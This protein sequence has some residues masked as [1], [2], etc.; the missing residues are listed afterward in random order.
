MSDTPHTLHN[1]LASIVGAENVIDDAE[2]LRSSYSQDKSP[3]PQI[4]PGIVVR[5]GAVE[6]IGEVL[7]L[8]NRTATPVTAR[9]GGF[10]L[11]GFL[12]GRDSIVVDPDAFVGQLNGKFTERL[13]HEPNFE[14]VGLQVHSLRVVVQRHD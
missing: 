13:S 7:K 1:E 2:L 12:Q 3:F 10:S 9:G 6:E 11:T 8:A 4:T 14:R 5:P